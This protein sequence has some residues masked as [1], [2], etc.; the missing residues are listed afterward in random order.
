M[1]RH[2]SLLFTPSASQTY[3]RPLYFLEFVIPEKEHWL[4]N[5]YRD[6]GRDQGPVMSVISALS[7]I[8]PI[9][10]REIKTWTRPRVDVKIK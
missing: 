9:R 6:S 4:C 1:S 2:I 7:S 5:I 3:E 10:K 8:S